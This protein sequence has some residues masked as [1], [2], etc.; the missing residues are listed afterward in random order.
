MC[1]YTNYIRNPKYIPNKKNDYN[2]PKLEDKRLMFIPAK[3]GKCSECRK[4]KKRHWNVRL[5]E[6]IRE[7]KGA[8]FI[9]LTF[10]D[11]GWEYA[12]LRTFGYKDERTWQEE[13]E[14]CATAIR[15][16]LERIRKRTK[17]SIRHWLIT[18]K[19]TDNNRIH[20]HGII[21]A[22]EE[23]IKKWDFGFTYKGT[24]VNEAT[25]NYITKY[26]LKMPENCP[27]FEGKIFAS[28]GIGSGYEKR[29]DAKRNAFKGI[30]TDETY[31]TRK[32]LILDLP[33]YYKDKIYSEEERE[34][35]WILKQERGYRYIGG[36]KVNT[37]DE[38]TIIELLKYYQRIS[39][40][41][42]KENPQQWDEEKQKKRLEL[43]GLIISLLAGGGCV[44]SINIQKDNYNS[45]QS[46]DQRNSTKNDSTN[47]N[48][49]KP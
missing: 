22:E 7:R 35:L 1:L 18:E 4:E 46:V 44:T 23:D 24:F 5:S 11:K 49:L 28:S 33:K 12:E 36:E 37:S 20:L 42:Y 38:K 48:L 43:I 16:W 2:P 25:I 34:K 6:E 29:L 14:I 31:R 32:G 27:T 21:W 8:K 47:L 15:L 9:T 26:I 17:K 30:L 3:C 39:K 40:E 45:N 19:G 41:T 13:N 10:S